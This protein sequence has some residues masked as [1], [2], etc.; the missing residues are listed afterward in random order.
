MTYKTQGII[1]KKRDLS[2]ADRLLTIYTK[3]FGKILVKGRAIKKS[4]AKLKGHL[5]LFMYSDLIIAEGRSMDVVIGAEEIDGFPII[6]YHL[7]SLAGAYCLSEIV[8]RLIA[9]PEYDQNI[10][11]LI[12]SAFQVSDCRGQNIDL[13][14][15]RFS[16]RLLDF[17]GY[18]D[19][20][21]QD[22]FEFIY[23][24]L[25]SEIYSLDF[26]RNVNCLVK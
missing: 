18:G 24:Q 13:V 21:Q 10:W 19:F 26:L 1:I 7:P 5:E 17:L 8:D 12:L 3:D 2:E 23:S 22:P 15:K 9:G 25:G 20:G 4:Q 11:Q 14:L 6:H 16:I